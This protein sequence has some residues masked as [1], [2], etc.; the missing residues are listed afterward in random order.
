MS[1]TLT[2]QSRKSSSTRAT[3]RLQRTSIMTSHF[4]DY[5]EMSSTPTTSSQSACQS[6]ALWKICHWTSSPWKSLD[7]VS[8]GEATL[9]SDFNVLFLLA[10]KTETSSASTRKLKVEVNAYSKADCQAVYGRSNLQIL[11]S[12]VRLNK[13]HPSGI[14]IYRFFFGRFARVELQA[15]IHGKWKFRQW[16]ANEM[17]QRV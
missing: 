3:I 12:Q 16:A 9:G 15:R 13:R 17:S 2:L 11:D 8:R 5:Q 1:P 10:G 14:E 6:T 4:S 7:G